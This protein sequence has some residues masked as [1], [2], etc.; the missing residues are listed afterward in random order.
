MNMVTPLVLALALALLEK[1]KELQNWL[2]AAVVLTYAP[3]LLSRDN[4][5]NIFLT[6]AEVK[7]QNNSD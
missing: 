5:F 4:T 6:H 3:C 2:H 1:L 7:S